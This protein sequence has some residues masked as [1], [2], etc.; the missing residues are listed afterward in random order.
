MDDRYIPRILEKVEGKYREEACRVLKG[1]ETKNVHF[2]P[3]EDSIIT[4]KS[5]LE[6]IKF[7]LNYNFQ[8]VL[9]E[10]LMQDVLEEYSVTKEGMADALIFQVGMN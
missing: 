9:T 6:V 4:I 10:R 5:T 7:L 2:K 8:Y 3:F 1:G